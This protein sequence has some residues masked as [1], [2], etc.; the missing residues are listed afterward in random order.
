MA[1]RI[2]AALLSGGRRSVGFAQVIGDKNLRQ[3][4]RELP[5]RLAR[6]RLDRR[7]GSLVMPVLDI[8]LAAAQHQPVQRDI[9]KFAERHR[10]LE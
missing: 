7:F 10:V 4:C 3:R 2:D 6:P 1:A 8:R 5:Q 9:E